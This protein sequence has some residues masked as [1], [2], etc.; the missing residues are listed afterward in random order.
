[1][2]SAERVAAHITVTV[3]VGA[4][5]LSF[6]ELHLWTVVDGLVVDLRAIPFDPYAVDEF[7]AEALAGTPSAG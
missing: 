7:F 3:G 2:A 4:K 6:E 5:R 1:M